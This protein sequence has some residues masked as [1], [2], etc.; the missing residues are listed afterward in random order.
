M[1]PRRNHFL[2]AV[3]IVLFFL[4]PL[5]WWTISLINRDSDFEFLPPKYRGRRLDFFTFIAVAEWRK[6]SLEEWSRHD[7]P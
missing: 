7:T 3:H 4:T 5:I 6:Y 2:N 1:I